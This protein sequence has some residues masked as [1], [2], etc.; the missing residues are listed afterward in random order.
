MKEIYSWLGTVDASRQTAEY[1]LKQGYSLTIFP[2]GIEEQIHTSPGRYDLYME[3][4]RHGG[5]IRLA[6]VHGVPL[7]PCFAFGPPNYFIPIKAAKNLQ[8]FLYKKFR[9]GIPFVTGRWNMVI[10]VKGSK[11]TIVVGKPLNLPRIPDPKDEDLE[12]YQKQY[13]QEVKRIFDQYKPQYGNPDDVL[14]IH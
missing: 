1:L 11:L 5:I 12:K 9:M 10:P 13:I 2:G 6:L 3:G 7:V 8:T 4:R 14:Q